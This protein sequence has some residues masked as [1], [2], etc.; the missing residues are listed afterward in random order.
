MNRMINYFWFNS[1]FSHVIDM[2]RFK[3][4]KVGGA[5]AAGG[6]AGAFG[7]KGKKFAAGG[8][9]AGMFVF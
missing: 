9:A 1:W 2:Y 4:G 6:M 5:F 8:V 7:K 3:F